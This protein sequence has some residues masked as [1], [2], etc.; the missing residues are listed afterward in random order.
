MKKK[1]KL[2][3]RTLIK[4]INPEQKVTEK[5][6]DRTGSPKRQTQRQQLVQSNMNWS[7]NPKALHE[8]YDQVGIPRRAFTKSEQHCGL[9]PENAIQRPNQRQPGKKKGHTGQVCKCFLTD[10]TSAGPQVRITTWISEIRGLQFR[11][12]CG[13]CVYPRSVLVT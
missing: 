7:A 11:H 4:V 9:F 10:R 13:I 2:P 1:S 12:F 6:T 8:H 3:G 5:Q